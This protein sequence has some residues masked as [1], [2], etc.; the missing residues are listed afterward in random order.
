MDG[1][2]LPLTISTARVSPDLLTHDTK[3]ALAHDHGKRKRPSETTGEIQQRV[4]TY[5][6]DEGSYSAALS[7]NSACCTQK[8]I[9]Q[10]AFTRLERER[11]IALNENVELKNTI[12]KSREDMSTLERENILLKAMLEGKK[13]ETEALKL[14][15]SE[16]QTRQDRLE[17]ENF[18]LKQ[19]ASISTRKLQE[20]NQKVETLSERVAS[21]SAKVESAYHSRWLVILYWRDGSDT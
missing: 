3:F 10:G 13:A 19:E 1:A 6:V 7:F 4:K 21:V 15:I 2:T 9:L 20:Y 11:M 16:M 5:V 8:F 14:R 12:M 17:A 18:S